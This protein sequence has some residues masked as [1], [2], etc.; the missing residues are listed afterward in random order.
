MAAIASPSYKELTQRSRSLHVTKPIGGR[1]A[2]LSLFSLGQPVV[3][4]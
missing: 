4:R 2:T 1:A 3:S